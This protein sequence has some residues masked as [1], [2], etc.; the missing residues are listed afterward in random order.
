MR[1]SRK[2]RKSGDFTHLESPGQGNG[3]RE[4]QGEETR[5]VRRQEVPATHRGYVRGQ[6][7]A[8]ARFCLDRVWRFDYAFPQYAI[9]LE[10]EG[11]IWTGGRHNRGK[12]FLE[13]M[14]KY[15]RAALDGWRVFRCTP[16]QLANGQ[17]ASLICRAIY[18][19]I[20]E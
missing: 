3:H 2:Q 14:E 4:G 12:G 13:D 17:A 6:R 18:E 16:K 15:N 9:A 11:G 19:G 10:V 1:R 8:G 7:R 5:Q 20:Y